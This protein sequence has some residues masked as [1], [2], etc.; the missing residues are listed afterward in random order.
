MEPQARGSLPQVRTSSRKYR[1]NYKQGANKPRPRDEPIRKKL[2]R[3]I[4]TQ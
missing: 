1:A 3:A 2:P 4:T